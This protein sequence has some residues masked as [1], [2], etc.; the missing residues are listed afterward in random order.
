MF[1]I[2][3]PICSPHSWVSMV[4]D[5]YGFGPESCRAHQS[6]DVWIGK[7]FDIGCECS[8]FN[9][10]RWNREWLSRVSRLAVLRFRESFV[11]I[12]NLFALNFVSSD[13]MLSMLKFSLVLCRYISSPNR[14]V[15]ITEW[16]KII[17]FAKILKVLITELK[18]VW[19][20][21]HSTVLFVF[22][23]PINFFNH[24]KF[25]AFFFYARFVKSSGYKSKALGMID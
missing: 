15:F 12:V 25:I 9:C 1:N 2:K 11:I 13:Q 14:I 18:W 16:E 10:S 24:C 5:D 4:K 20:Q 17:K 7:L 3:A 8:L 23:S 22:K 6:L 19:L 21:F